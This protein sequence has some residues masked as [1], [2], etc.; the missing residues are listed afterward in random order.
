VKFGY[1]MLNITTKGDTE[2]HNVYRSTTQ[3]VRI[4]VLLTCVTL[5]LGSP[6]VFSLR[7]T[8]TLPLTPKGQ[9]LASSSYQ[10][11]VVLNYAQIFVLGLA[12]GFFSA[13]GTTYL[14][15]KTFSKMKYTKKFTDPN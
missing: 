5:E 8:L 13:L 9:D 6:N 11:T 2:G 12:R 1:E 14:C 15:G 10:H 3:L 4:P 7:A